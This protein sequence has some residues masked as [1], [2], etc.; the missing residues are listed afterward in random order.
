MSITHRRRSALLLAALVLGVSA[1]GSDDGEDAGAAANSAPKSG[2]KAAA[3][4]QTITV[5]SGAEAESLDPQ[6][7]DD[8]GN[9][10]VLWRVYETL[11]DFD[12]DGK[13]V[14]LLA[15][16]EATPVDDTTWEVKLKPN[17][18]FSDGQPFDADAV[19]AS[20]KRILD[21]KFAT[22]FT[23][24]TTIESA[25]KVDDRTV[26]FTTKGPD[27]LLPNRLAILKMLPP[28]LPD[29]FPKK[30]VGTGPYTLSSYQSGGNAV[31]KANPKYWGPKPQV[32]TVKIRN[33]PDEGTRLQALNTGEVQVVPGLAPEQ[34][35]KAPASVASSKP[36]Y[37][38]LVRVNTIKGALANPD[39][40]K[41]LAHSIDRKSM[42]ESLFKDN[43][44]PSACQP[45]PVHVGN[46]DLKEYAFDLDAAK[47][48]ATR[49]G[50]AGKTVNLTWTT[51][52]FPQDRL[53]G[54]AVA[55]GMQQ[56]G[57]KVKL[58]LKN[59]KAFLEDIYV[60]GAD[61]PDMVFTESDNNLGS[62]ASKVGLFY[63]SD[64]PVSSVK[65]PEMDRL[66]DAASKE[67]EPASRDAAYNKVLA[68]G[69]EQA[70]LIE[71][72]ERKE[73]YGLADNLE[74]APNPVA[75]SKM[76]YDRMKVVK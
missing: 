21:K 7:K 13:L 60:K 56:S 26:R 34:A 55:Q 43:A 39:A 47:D 66:L 68:R 8:D 42:T 46:R 53:V 41:A 37:V 32:T 30:A 75:Y 31:L 4:N 48:L 76:Y 29:G 52:V 51:G 27:G 10:I 49:S 16:G 12:A 20:V 44:I 17:I 1:C 19:V 45:T 62:P 57:I 35:A 67:L 2:G 6:V 54:Q 9:S 28:K 63:A 25:K 36:A 38:G 72:Y 69:C 65:D 15:D 18:T 33:I 64:G 24:V 61:A 70:D 14:P 3:G 40:R 59:Y 74:Y 58:E 73:I 11:Y 50:A 22:G 71:I 23:E 5:A